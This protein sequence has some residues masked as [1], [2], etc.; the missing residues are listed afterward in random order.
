VRPLALRSY[1]ACWGRYTQ[2][3][4]IGLYGSLNLFGY[5]ED[6]P[7]SFSDSTGLLTIDA[8]S[9]AGSCCSDELLK[10][11]M[12]F[13]N[14]FR[15][16]FRSR[17]P[18]CRDRLIDLNRWVRTGSQFSVLTCMFVGT[19]TMRVTCTKLDR[20]N[21]GGPPVFSMADP[22]IVWLQPSVCDRGKCG[23]P[24]NTLMHEALHNC[25]APTE[26]AP[27][28]GLANEIAEECVGR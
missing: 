13:D 19:R 28:G 20:G 17:S 26:G 9:C 27:G 7:T 11:R 21:C 10:A 8:A 1:A 6:R 4:P 14:L 12:E 24:L 25:G 3:D 16:G 2:P 22:G 15:P 18:R 23:S 5:A